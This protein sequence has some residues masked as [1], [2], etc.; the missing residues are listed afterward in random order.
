MGG[1]DFFS[2][3]RKGQAG[4]VKLAWK[5]KNPRTAQGHSGA[6]N[7]I[8]SR[9]ETTIFASLGGTRRRGGRTFF[10]F[11]T[12]ARPFVFCLSAPTPAAK[13]TVFLLSII[14]GY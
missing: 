2:G 1:K 12:A 9:Q 8:M 3:F 5:C 13:T 11:K 4:I 6:G 7:N 14:S 10:D